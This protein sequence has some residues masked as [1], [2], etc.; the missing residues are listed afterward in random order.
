MDKLSDLNEKSEYK[1]IMEDYSNNYGYNIGLNTFKGVG[2]NDKMDNSV[3][4]N[5]TVKKR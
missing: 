4:G 3:K 5:K 2:I 1:K